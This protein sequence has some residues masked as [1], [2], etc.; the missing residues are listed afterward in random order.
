[1]RKIRL[2]HSIRA[3][4]LLGVFALIGMN[5]S[6]QEGLYMTG[7]ASVTVNG[8]A[9]LVIGTLYNTSTGL[10]A[11]NGTVEVAGNVQNDGSALFAAASTGTVIF[12]GTAAQEITGTVPVQFYG[13]VEIDNAAGVALTNTVT[14]SDAVMHGQ[15]T[16]TDGSFTL[17]EF[18]LTLEV[19]AVGADAA[20]YF[21]TN[22]AGSLKRSVPA[23][24]AT[25]VVYP[26]GNSVYNPVTLQNSATATTDIY[27][28]IVADSKP[29]NFAG[30][31]HIVDRSW[32]ITEDVAG[33]SDLTLTTQ[34]NGTDELDPFDRTNSTHGV[35]AD[36]GTTVTWGNSAAATGTD[37]YAL[38]STGISV[39][40]TFMVG[41]DYY[42]T[43][44]IDLK[45]FL[46][47]AYNAANHNMDNNLNALLPLTDPYGVGTTV[48]AI[49]ATAVDWI[50]IELRD[51]NDR[52]NVLY[53]FARFIDQDGQVINENE[54][55]CEL[56]GVTRDSYYIAVMHRN[57]FGVVSNNTVDLTATPT[58]SFQTAQAT[59]WQDAGITT[60]TA[61]M[62]VE[63]GV[64]ALWSGDANG[65]G[66]IS[67]EGGSNDRLE[68]L[69]EVGE[70]TPTN[71]L[72]G[73]YNNAD[74][75]MDGNVSYEGAG[76]DR[77]LVLS[78]VWVTTPTNTLSVHLP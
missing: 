39:L 55:N 70:L 22:G 51:K 33:G 52:S 62:E 65:N 50:K 36:N 46:A 9:T 72:Y 11:N 49:P 14:G 10:I 48:T 30:T 17:N 77:L 68:I 37:P 35:T 12:N 28:V 20:K 60:N 6:A 71:V 53:S 34:W 42:S 13:D 75:N 40:G 23:D 73:V 56:P 16:F 18:D 41:D 57:H 21:V 26:V 4:S 1:M 31:D 63:T 74:V 78:S 8:G 19:D 7:D 44:N 29:A 64:F 3:L 43:I 61:M 5:T 38:T 58:L 2:L 32:V 15:L 67:Y 47:G 45:I 24:G 76:S 69:T 66:I 54:T 59:A 25:N 27:G